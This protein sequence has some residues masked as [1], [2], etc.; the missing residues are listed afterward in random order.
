MGSGNTGV[1]LSSPSPNPCTGELSAT[2]SVGLAAIR[3]EAPNCFFCQLRIMLF[4]SFFVC[5]KTLCQWTFIPNCVK[6]TEKSVR[7][8]N[9][10]TNGAEN[11]KK[12]IKTAMTNSVVDD[13]WLGRVSVREL[14]E[15]IHDVSKSCIDNILTNN[16]VLPRFVQGG[17][18]ECSQKRPQLAT[19]RSSPQIYSGLG[20]KC[21]G[22]LGLYIVTG[23]EIW[24]HYRTPEMKQDFTKQSSISKLE[25]S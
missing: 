9:T 12:D 14:C 22:I 16:L 8:Y 18:L 25:R 1:K 24:N 19:S 6:P 4:D 23:D 10:C 3:Y 15:T 11:S 5:A 13:N 20:N 2:L 7:V 17:S 21:R